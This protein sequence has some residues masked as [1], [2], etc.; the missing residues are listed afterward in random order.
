M[1]TVFAERLKELRLERG[2]GQV[3]LARCLGVSK[4]V[5]SLW[6]NAKREP[7]LSSLVA[8]AGYFEVS[9]DF[10]CGLSD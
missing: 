7:T 9:L 5:I 10:L 3:E 8:V 4:G 1:N 6:E 2:V